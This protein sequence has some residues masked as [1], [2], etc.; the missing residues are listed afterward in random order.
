MYGSSDAR[1]FLELHLNFESSAYPKELPNTTRSQ[2]I[3]QVKPGVDIWSK[4]KHIM[5]YN[6]IKQGRSMENQGPRRSID[7]VIPSRS[8]DGVVRPA[9]PAPTQP[10]EPPKAKR[11]GRRKNATQ[12]QVQPA[13][14]QPLA[15]RP[16]VPVRSMTPPAKAQPAVSNQTAAKAVP[17]PKKRGL[18]RFLK[19][20]L[21]ILIIAAA[22]AGIW[23]IY[24][25]Y[26]A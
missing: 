8:M 5:V 12:P 17:K 16:V 11:F 22:L 3:I 21:G 23:L 9:R 26:Y 2:L 4:R 13:V 19:F 18:R 24:L 20:L 14:V 1:L 15:P 7:G 25:H 10:V 6:W